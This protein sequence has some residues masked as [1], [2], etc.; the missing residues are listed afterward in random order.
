MRVK[1]VLTVFIE[2]ASVLIHLRIRMIAG[3]VMSEEVFDLF[4]FFHQHIIE[5]LDL[6]ICHF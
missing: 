2:A 3:G 5:F 6:F 4:L 1:G